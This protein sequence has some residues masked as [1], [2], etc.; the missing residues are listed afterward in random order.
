MKIL[1]VETQQYNVFDTK[2]VHKTRIQ[3]TKNFQDINK[4]YL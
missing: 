4:L 3:E 2:K 1:V